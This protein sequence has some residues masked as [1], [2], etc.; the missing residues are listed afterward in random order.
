MTDTSSTQPDSAT[1]ASLA[2]DLG[3]AI[4]A[5]CV[6][7]EAP[8]LAAYEKGW[9]YGEGRARMVLKPR[10]VEHVA[11]A[12]RLC[13]SAG[14]RIQP[15]GANTGL[16]AASNPDD[17]GEM[18]VL[19]LERLSKTIQV[20]PEDGTVIVDGGV[21]LSQLNE[22]LAAHGRSFP[23]DLGADPQIGGMIVTN[24]GGS[25]LVRY[26]DVRANL[27][28][29][30]VVLPT[31]EVYTQLDRLA[32]N[33]TG[34]DAKQLF[35][36]TSGAFGIVTRAVLKT[37]PLPKQT[38]GAL[39]CATS[40]AAVVELLQRLEPV[41]GDFLSAF[42][43]IS[44]NATEAVLRHGSLERQPFA[45]GA[46]AYAVL[47]EL[48]C[49]L[50]AEV[51]DLEDVLGMAL[52]SAME[53]MPEG[54]EDVVVGDVED[55][56]SIRHQVSESLREEGPVLGLD[57]STPRGDMARFT[58]EVEKRVHEVAPDVRVCDFGHWG[59]G[60]SHLN[61]VL[62]R[63]MDPADLAALKRRL[64]S[65]VYGIC[66]EEFG[67]SYS[68]EHGVGPHNIAAYHRYTDPVVRRLCA[69]IAT[70]RFGTVDL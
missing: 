13:R 45:E 63:D 49:S 23:I 30:E 19:S 26:G 56:W 2:R 46:P 43:A 61:L 36:G 20:F 27:L 69:S 39:V 66:V 7:T 4:G 15:I 25:R 32:K 34:L 40:G 6:F 64:Q 41:V 22:A 70:E 51:L 1:T 21:L 47:V 35:V 62:K 67:G 16:V 48:Q 59:D 8:D 24:T 17:S 31:G 9:R 58:A 53:A 18:A 14:V 44:R 5:D 54:V 11:A 10:T 37:W 29:L 33:N 55:F 57:V 28:G 60:G 52:E 3:D 42:E 38:V 50:P 68:A 65:L 12:V